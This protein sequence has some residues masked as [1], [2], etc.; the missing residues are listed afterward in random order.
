MQSNSPAIDSG[1][2]L[3]D[4]GISIDFDNNNRL[5]E[6]TFDIGA[7]EYQGNNSIP[8]KAARG[9]YQKIKT[10]SE[11]SVNSSFS[12]NQIN[13]VKDFSIFPNPSNGNFTFMKKANDTSVNISVFDSMGHVVYTQNDI[14]DNY[15]AVNLNVTKGMYYFKINNNTSSTTNKIIIQ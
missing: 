9:D 3:V 1:I 13:L 8:F 12:D 11:L 4:E 6:S 14:A 7:F 5:S 15:T 10:L 2:N